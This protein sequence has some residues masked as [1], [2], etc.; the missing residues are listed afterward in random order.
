MKGARSKRRKT[1]QSS[2]K[3]LTLEGRAELLQ[4]RLG[5]WVQGKEPREAVGELV[6]LFHDLVPEIVAEARSP[7]SALQAFMESCTAVAEQVGGSREAFLSEALRGMVLE[8]T[9]GKAPR[10]TVQKDTRE[11]VLEAALEVFSEKG[12][13]HATMDEIA[14]RAGVGKGTVYR[15]FSN[16]ENLFRQL[17]QARLRELER[18]AEAVLDS[19]DD[20]LTLIEKYL[21]IYFSFFD[22]NQR[23]YRVMV[24]EHPDL[25][26]R[27][28]DLYVEKIMRRIPRL[29]RK[30]YEA[31]Q[32]NVLKDVNFPTVFYG[33][34]GFLHGVIQR[35]LAQ[36]CAYSLEQELATVKEVLFYGFVKQN[37]T[38]EEE[39]KWT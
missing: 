8:K 22:R 14:E 20:V 37:E 32:R 2:V 15:Y 30:I 4:E 12:F 19:D 7:D 10:A 24:Q 36:D 18:D 38:T 11:R 17:V 34:M 6:S 28:Q 13:H 3:T 5:K 33:V 25:G 9:P 27:V 31:R 23:L 39:K 35:W 21:R 16:K 1:F 29:K 26:D